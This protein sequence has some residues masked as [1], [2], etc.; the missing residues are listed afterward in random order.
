MRKSTG[1]PTPQRRQRWNTCFQIYVILFPIPTHIQPKQPP[2]LVALVG[3]GV[4]WLLIFSLETSWQQFW[5]FTSSAITGGWAGGSHRCFTRLG[6]GEGSE[7]L[8][9]PTLPK[10]GAKGPR[11]SPALKMRPF[12]T[13][14]CSSLDQ[15]PIGSEKG[16]EG[17]VLRASAPLLQPE[18]GLALELAHRIQLVYEGR[19]NFQCWRQN[20]AME[21]ALV[22]TLVGRSFSATTLLSDLNQSFPSLLLSFPYLK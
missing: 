11:S 8:T 1:V 10:L 16:G 2:L 5:Q 13:V 6:P 18:N 15:E 7:P 9:P 12:L 17:W 14:E 20:K 4:H 19:G 22:G 21:R 3:L